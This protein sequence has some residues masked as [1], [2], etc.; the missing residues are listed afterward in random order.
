MF[1]SRCIENVVHIQNRIHPAIK[2]NDIKLTGKWVGGKQKAEN[3][4]LI[5]VIQAQKNKHRIPI[6]FFISR[7]LPLTVKYVSLS[8]S[9]SR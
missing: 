4:T 5:E 7:S 2:K 8:E 9:K 3:I 1:I 6:S